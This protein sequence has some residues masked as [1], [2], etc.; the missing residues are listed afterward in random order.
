MKGDEGEG[1]GTSSAVGHLGDKAIRVSFEGLQPSL[2]LSIVSENEHG[3][4]TF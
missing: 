1:A 3:I 2:P 4:T